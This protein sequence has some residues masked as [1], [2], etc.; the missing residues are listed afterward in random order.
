MLLI[1]VT[2]QLS[3]TS[4]RDPLLTLRLLASLTHVARAAQR[5][6][7]QAL[8]ETQLEMSSRLF[9]SLFR[10][11]FWFDNKQETFSEHGHEEMR[12]CTV[13][14]CFCFLPTYFYVKLQTTA[15]ALCLHLNDFM[16]PL[17][18]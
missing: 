5:I 18:G 15:L 3:S 11:M 1:A 16:F 8:D 9:L 2:A 7:W 13:K 10:S 4:S 17:F 14:L 12:V 6:T